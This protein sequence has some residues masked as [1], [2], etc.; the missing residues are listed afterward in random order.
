VRGIDAIRTWE[1]PTDGIVTI[2][3]DATSTD[4]RPTADVQ[5]RITMNGATIWPDRG[6]ALLRPSDTDGIPA[7]VSAEMHAGDR[8]SFVTRTP[9]SEK[10]AD[11]LW[12]PVCTF[13]GT[14][15]SAR[16]S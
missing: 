8:I 3:G 5:I 9:G 13:C 7:R 11:V 16:F 10:V 2:N 12:D 4:V 1:A 6:W 14:V 15:R